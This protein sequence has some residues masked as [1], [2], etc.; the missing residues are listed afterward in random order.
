MTENT[1]L[2]EEKTETAENEGENRAIISNMRAIRILNIWYVRLFL[3]LIFAFFV[4]SLIIPLRP[5]YSENE[6][7]EL[8]KFPKFTLSSF[9]SGDFFDGI[10]SW[11]ADTFP[12]REGLTDLNAR[13]TGLY[14]ITDTRIHGTVEQGDEI[15][16]GN[17]ESA[18][19]SESTQGEP[20]DSS[21]SAESVTEDKVVISE[22]SETSSEQSSASSKEEP[23]SAQTLGALLISGDTAYEYY[24]FVKATADSYVSAVNRAAA[25]LDGKATV[26]DMIVPTSMG[27]CAPDKLLA[28][29]N[30]S[31]QKKATDYMYSGMKGVKTVPVFDTLKAHNSEYIYFRTDHHW[32]ALGAYYAYGELIRLKGGTPTPLDSFTVRE[33]PNYLGSFYTSSGK[34]PQLAANPDTVYA[35]QPKETNLIDIQYENGVWKYG[36]EIISDMSAASQGSKYLTF[37][38]GDRPFSIIK[39]P[40][41]TDNSACIVIKESFGNAFVPFLVAHYQNVYIVDYRYF[42]KVDSRGLAQLQADTGASDVLFINNISATRNKSL[43]ASINAFVR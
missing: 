21:S 4:L 16:D 9:L 29:V 8:A 11:Y 39:N 38:K 19:S 3:L 2:Q 43:V 31:D 17:T 24:N 36:Q 28:G 25:L 6:K 18:D 35:Y 1:E 34:L 37:I 12:L 15:P 13:V 20:A 23:P 22:P 30:T 7:R 14:G 33:F 42:N 26:Y 32:T 40:A 41:L 27:I 5:K 10:N